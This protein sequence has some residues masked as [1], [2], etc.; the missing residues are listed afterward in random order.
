MRAGRESTSVHQGGIALVVVLWLV[1]L[2]A[3][4]A[5][6]QSATVRTETLV[7]GNLVESANA[8]AAAW[9]GLQLAI[10]DLAKP[11][12]ARE[13]SRDS[14]IN[15]LR[16]DQANLSVAITDESG[17]VDINVA[18]ATVLGKLFAASG[19]IQERRE[20]LV[21]AIL[22]WR[23]RDSLRRL[24]GAEE[25]EYRVAGLDY[26]PRN[27]PFQSL[28]ELAL[29]IG[30][31][32]SLYHALIENLTIY[33]GDAAINMQV[34]TPRLRQALRDD[35]DSL[36]ND[37]HLGEGGAEADSYVVLT[38]RGMRS[39]GA[40]FSI[41]VEARLDNGVREQVDAVVRFMPTRANAPLRYEFLRWREG[42]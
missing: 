28:E 4:M 24:N 30:V 29:V 2:L 5:V 17:K 20:A 31:D 14:S 42:R 26:G 16:F 6:S 35:G 13:M 34:A 37:D 7:V 18:S 12:P 3:L 41:A 38:A 25:E 27:G 15:T 36:V 21:D 23:D 33:A 9:A 11:I 39:T 22:D 10:A 32:A 40:V 8:R 19:V 1:A